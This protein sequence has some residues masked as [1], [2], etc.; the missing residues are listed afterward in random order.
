MIHLHLKQ[1][2]MSAYQQVNLAK[3]GDDFLNP[4][5]I[6]SERTC[7]VYHQD[8]QSRHFKMLKFWIAHANFLPIYITINSSDRTNLLQ[9][10]SDPKHADISGMPY[11]I[12]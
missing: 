6:L 5:V 10:I 9:F 2:G 4:G 12:A 1:M 3:S 11:L 7:D 8:L